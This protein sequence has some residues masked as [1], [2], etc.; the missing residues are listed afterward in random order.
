MQQASPS[1]ASYQM[2]TNHGCLS[3][4]TSMAL[5]HTNFMVINLQH[6]LIDRH[7]LIFTQF[8]CVILG[9]SDHSTTD[10]TPPKVD[11]HIIRIQSLLPPPHPQ[12]PY[13][14]LNKSQCRIRGIW[15]TL[16]NLSPI[17]LLRVVRIH[18]FLTKMLNVGASFHLVYKCYIPI[19][20]YDL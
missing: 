15:T 16:P 9:R 14:T 11:A 20:F 13:P 17:Y 6:S 5:I 4:W 2:A 1:L 3:T 10:L 18:H 8:S 19:H 12:E 7:M